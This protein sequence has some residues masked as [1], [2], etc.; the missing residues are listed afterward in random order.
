[1][2]KVNSE[3]L[4]WNGLD[5]AKPVVRQKVYHSRIKVVMACFSSQNFCGKRE[6]FLQC[7]YVI[8]QTRCHPRRSGSISSVSSWLS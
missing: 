1:M 7:P 2:N 6:P 3:G 4:T 8:G 5:L